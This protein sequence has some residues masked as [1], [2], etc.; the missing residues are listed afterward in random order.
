VPREEV[1][2]RV[3]VTAANTDDEVGELLAV[4]DRLVDVVPLR[5]S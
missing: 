5:R 4:L 3:Q 1:G 2:F